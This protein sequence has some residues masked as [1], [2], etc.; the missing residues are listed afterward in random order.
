M[1]CPNC[2]A[3]MR[4]TENEDSLRCE[5][6]RGVYTPEQNDDGVRLLG[7][8][9]KLGCPVCAVPLEQ[10]ALGEHRILSCKNC[11]GMLVPMGNFVALVEELRTGRSGSGAIQP[12]PDR[13]GLD[14]H[15]SCPQCHQPM[16][17]HFYEGPGNII[18]DDCSRCLLNWLDRGE[19]MRVVRA[20][21]H[22]YA[23]DKYGR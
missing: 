1:N 17:T 14:R 18:I 23:E 3:P 11:Q 20:P 12:A 16:D 7:E 5:Y 9:S 21:N 10:A 2:G 8:T 19:L 15:L 6:C 4:V 22:V 13:K